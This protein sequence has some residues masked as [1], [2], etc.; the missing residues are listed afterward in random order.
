MKPRCASHPSRRAQG[1][2]PHD[3]A[4]YGRRRQLPPRATDAVADTVL[5]KVF[6]RRRQLPR[7]LRRAAARDGAY[8][9]PR[10]RTLSFPRNWRFFR[11][12]PDSTFAA[13]RD[14][15]DPPPA[16]AARLDRASLALPD[17]KSAARS[18]LARA[19]RPFKGIALILASTVFLGASDVTANICR[20]ACRR[21]RSPGSGF[22]V[23]ADHVAAMWP[24]S[25]LFACI[26]RARACN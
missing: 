8:R 15:R 4:N 17:K 20:R 2:A 19:D 25:P 18:A 24:G 7:R 26:P 14:C 22:C 21:S 11:A 6:Q 23:R 5:N 16:A 10:F 9:R 1:R 13:F 12:S 3:E